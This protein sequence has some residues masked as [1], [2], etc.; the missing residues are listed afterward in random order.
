M[1]NDRAIISLMLVGCLAGSG[2]VYAMLT[3]G[4]FDWLDGLAFMQMWRW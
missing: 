3:L 4:L 1:T 2:C